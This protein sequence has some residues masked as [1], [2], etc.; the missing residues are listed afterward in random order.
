MIAGQGPGGE[1]QGG[2]VG[3]GD[4]WN[5]IVCMGLFYCTIS[6]SFLIVWS[7]AEESR[8]APLL[9]WL[10]QFFLLFGVFCINA[11]KGNLLKY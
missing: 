11:D 6:Q 3:G 7:C 8:A 4:G 9:P 2:A 5:H 10:T 1:C